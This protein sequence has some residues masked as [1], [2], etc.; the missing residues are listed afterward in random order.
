MSSDPELI[1]DVSDFL[2]SRPDD[3]NLQAIDDETERRELFDRLHVRYVER[4]GRDFIE[5]SGVEEAFGSAYAD[6]ERQ[7][8]NREAERRFSKVLERYE[9]AWGRSYEVIVRRRG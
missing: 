3:W 5:S 6:C 9:L 4:E 2:R 8:W 1:T 7:P